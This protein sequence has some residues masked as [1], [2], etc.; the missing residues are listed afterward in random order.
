MVFKMYLVSKSFSHLLSYSGG[1]NSA[2]MYAA[3]CVCSVQQK[4]VQSVSN[5][6]YIILK[7][8]ND[9]NRLIKILTFLLATHHL[10]VFAVY[11]TSKKG[12]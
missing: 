11:G 4:L 10:D 12:D 6:H 5:Q 3:F 2:M 1:N 7:D 8:R 9:R